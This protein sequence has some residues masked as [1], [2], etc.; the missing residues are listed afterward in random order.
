MLLR[1]PQDKYIVLIQVEEAPPTTTYSFFL[2]STGA[3]S[4]WGTCLVK[5]KAPT[6]KYLR[7]FWWCLVIVA[8]IWKQCKWASAGNCVYLSGASREEDNVL[9]SEELG[10]KWA[11]LVS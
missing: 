1:R 4:L 2:Q 9:A 8:K 7:L 11:D 3:P 5:L 10:R 6:W